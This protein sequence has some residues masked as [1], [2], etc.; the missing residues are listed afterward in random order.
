[1]PAFSF[2][3]F[4]PCLQT[5]YVF[6]EISW[7]EADVGIHGGDRRLLDMDWKIRSRNREP[8]DKTKSGKGPLGVATP[9]N[10]L[11]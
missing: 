11:T 4:D 9:D 5:F 3:L 8:S 7:S 1:M 2:A 10:S 6:G